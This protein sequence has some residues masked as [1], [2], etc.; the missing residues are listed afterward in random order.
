MR[1]RPDWIFIASVKSC[2]V[3]FTA[4]PALRLSAWAMSSICDGT[5]NN[6]RNH[7]SGLR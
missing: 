4:P 3:A 7:Y 2:N 5:E 6:V 1:E